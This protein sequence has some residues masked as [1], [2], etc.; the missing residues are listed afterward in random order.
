MR[1]TLANARAAAEEMIAEA[2]AALQRQGVAVENIRTVVELDVRYA[3]QSFDLTIPFD[4]DETALAEAFHQRH[5]RRYGYA[6]ARRTSRT[7]HRSASPASV[8]NCHPEL[9]EGQ[10]LSD[11]D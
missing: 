10:P 1:A 6:V 9:V 11:G 7:R 8:Q 3:G 4:G 5:E 2:R